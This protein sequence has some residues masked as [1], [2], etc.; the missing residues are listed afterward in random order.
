MARTPAP[1]LA[2]V[3]SFIDCINRADLDSLA[4]LLHENH[5]L[6]I[7]DEEPLVGR[8]ENVSAWRG[9]FEAFPAYVIYPRYMT[10]HEGR[11]AVLGTTT[12]SHL[13][14]PDHVEAQLGVL[15]QADVV[16]GLLTRW[17]VLDDDERS[18][19]DAGIP[20]TAAI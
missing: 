18:R 13:G 1:P 4:G 11:V 15:W 20:A 7:L 9:Y 2:A 3:V 5:R 8:D 10:S 17:A 19:A 16:D 12:G 14:L 6:E